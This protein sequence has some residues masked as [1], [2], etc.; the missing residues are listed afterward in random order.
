M[1]QAAPTKEVTVDGVQPR[2]EAK[3]VD[4]IDVA[5]GAQA[6]AIHAVGR[7]QELG[8]VGI[9]RG[10]EGWR[11]VGGRCVSWV[12]AQPFGAI[13]CVQVSVGVSGFMRARSQG[14]HGVPR[15]TVGA[16]A[17]QALVRAAS[18]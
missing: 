17:F 11:E 7:Q 18:C 8:V 1:R 16:G 13:G 5:H 14:R 3:V 4:A 12:R 9:V 10:D 15:A 2:E 6:V